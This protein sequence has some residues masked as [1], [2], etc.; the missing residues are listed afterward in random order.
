MAITIALACSLV[1]AGLTLLL[2]RMAAR[3]EQEDQRVAV[4][5]RPQGWRG[6][7]YRQAFGDDRCSAD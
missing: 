3:A 2:A 7:S 4:R 5:R 6:A 1:A